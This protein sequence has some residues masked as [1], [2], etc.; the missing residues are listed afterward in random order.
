MNFELAFER[1]LGHEGAYVHHP[2]D[3]GGETR[4][5]ISA[6]TARQHGYHG[7]MKALSSDLAKRIYR[8]SYW[9]ALACDQLP[10]ALAFQLFDAGVNHGPR[11]AMRLLQQC[12][13]VYADG[14]WGEKTRAAVFSKPQF[15]LIVMFNLS[16]ID[17]YVAQPGF[18]HFGRGWM[19]RVT[20]NLRYAKEDA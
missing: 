11:T 7:E 19:R 18:V 6:T 15:D 2:E 3:P 14:I 10:P 5:G 13:G 16:R 12:A 20:Q 17:F 1:V 8:Q 9:Q 4:W